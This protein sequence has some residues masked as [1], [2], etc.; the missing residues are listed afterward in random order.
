LNHTLDHILDSVCAKVS[1]YPY[2]TK[3]SGF[4]VLEKGRQ[5]YIPALIFWRISALV[6][7]VSE[8]VNLGVKHERGKIFSLSAHI[9]I[10]YRNIRRIYFIIRAVIECLLALNKAYTFY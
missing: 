1:Y 3:I 4:T 10:N 9:F 6:S 5:K 8:K 2:A 7:D